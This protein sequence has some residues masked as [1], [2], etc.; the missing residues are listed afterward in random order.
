MNGA[1]RPSVAYLGPAGTFSEEALARAAGSDAFDPVP[2]PTVAEAAMAV[3]RGEADRA[4]VPFENSIEG[5]VRATLDVLAFQAEQT[6]IVGEFDHPIRHSLIAAG[7]RPMSEITAVLSHPQ[8]IPQCMQFLARELPTAEVRP[9]SSTAEA[10]REVT[11][12]D[13]PWAALGTSR[14]AELYDAVELRQS[15]EDFADNVTR[16]VWLAPDSV[17]AEAR[18]GGWKTSLVISELSDR[19]G[20]LVE[21]LDQFAAR[22]VNLTR[23]E[24]RPQRQ[25][26]GRYLFFVDLEGALTDAAVAEALAGVRERAE[27]VRVLGSFPVVQPGIP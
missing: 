17:V 16:F 26:L 27:R 14:A 21:L 11:A 9:V 23:I 2:R 24:S 19:P 5:T 18:D 6:A 10:V 25:A 1:R 13:E 22:S 3:A 7:R 20:A 4:F 12:S 15:V 8:A